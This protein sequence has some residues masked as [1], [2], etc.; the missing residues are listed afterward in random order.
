MNHLNIHLKLKIYNLELFL[1]L[2][3]A[4]RISKEHFPYILRSGKRYNS[5]NLSLYLAP[6]A[7]DKN[8]V[9]FSFSISKKVSPLA[10]NRNKYRRWGYSAIA[11]GLK[12]IKPGYFYF[13]SFKKPKNK[14]SFWVLNE[15]IQELLRASNML[16]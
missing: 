5:P 1:M 8:Q 2:S 13:F 9:R 16:I 7:D 11:G 4:N 3:K 10:V 6:I 14:V 15:E 12:I